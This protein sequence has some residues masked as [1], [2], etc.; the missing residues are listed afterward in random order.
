MERPALFDIALLAH[1]PGQPGVYLMKNKEGQVIYVGKAKHLKQR[2]KQY[3]AKGGDARPMVPF[4]IEQTTHID[5]IVVPSEKE[6]LLLENTLIKK[7]QPKFNA[8]LKDDKTFVSLMINHHHPWPRL[9]LVR[10][11]GRPPTDG[12]YF[13]PYTSAE[14]ARQTYELLIRL[15][16]LR[17]CSDQELKRRTRPCILHAIQRCSAPCVKRCSPEIYA[18]YVERTIAFLKGQD[19]ELLRRLYQEME[20][21]SEALEYEKAAALLKTIRQIEHVLQ[22]PKIATQVGRKNT[23]ALNF[24]R[25]GDE[26][27]LVQLLF[28]EGHLVGSESFSFSR[29]LEDDEELI[30]SFLLQHYLS[31]ESPPEE[32]L[33]PL[34]LPQIKEIENILSERWNRS[35]SLLAPQKGDKQTLVALAKDNAIAL[36]SQSKDQELLQEKR[37]LDLQE[38]LKLNRYPHHIECFDTSHMAGA[39]PVAAMV[40]FIEGE[41]KPELYRLFKIKTAPSSDDYAAIREVLQRHL[42][43][44]KEADRLPD[45]ILIDGG[46]G[47]LHVALQVL[48]ELNIISVDVIG[49]AKETGRHDKGISKEKIYLPE[50]SDPI[51]LNPHSSILFLLQTI[52]DE[53]HRKA[54]SFYRLRHKKNTLTSQLDLIPGIGKVKKQELLRHFGSAERVF[55]ASKKEL[56]EIP[57]LS[58]KDIDLLHNYKARPIS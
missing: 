47:H 53:A 25:Q 33:I 14:A 46:K 3:Y 54:I 8:I 42:K 56:E 2:I 26:V 55:K 29:C 1:F 20:E 15:F 35:I 41:K 34:L 48:S 58:Q 28:R 38:I 36:F 52:R 44:A 6:A 31:Q 9:Q 37:L 13:G 49:I 4:L 12:L 51:L 16:P 23:D 24:Y 30:A 22:P 40:S 32:I 27:I 57:S 19:K 5:T 21:A 50:Q 7:H 17:Q 11:K 43:R 45:L 39:H 10:Y 18:Q